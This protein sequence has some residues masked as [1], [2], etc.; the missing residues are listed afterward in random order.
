MVNRVVHTEDE[1]DGILE[2]VRF[3]KERGYYLNVAPDHFNLSQWSPASQQKLRELIHPT[4]F[5]LKME[6]QTKG[7]KCI[8]PS[9][10]FQLLPNGYAWMPPCD[11]QVI[12][13]MKT[14]DPGP[15]LFK[16]GMTCP[17]DNCVC[18]HQYSFIANDN[19]M[20]RNT[21]S[22]DILNNYV[23]AQSEHRAARNH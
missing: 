5:K 9:F 4:D 10:G 15:L 16:G 13:L 14:R 11:D 17:S 12:N 20:A 2:E 1:M 23:T 19:V 22:M 21:A 18:L 3:F 6:K 8:Y 7:K